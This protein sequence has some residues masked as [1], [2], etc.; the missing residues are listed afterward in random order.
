MPYIIRQPS[1]LKSSSSQI[2]SE[3]ILNF[4]RTST[5]IEAFF[6]PLVSLAIYMLCLPDQPYN[7]GWWTISIKDI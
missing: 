1:S 2:K 5:H 6:F 7:F 3:K 4:G